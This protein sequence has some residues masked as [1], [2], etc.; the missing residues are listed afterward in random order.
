MSF[1]QAKTARDRLA[2]RCPMHVDQA[3][4]IVEQLLAYVTALHSAGR[5]HG[6]I[7]AQLIEVADDGALKLEEP[8]PVV[9]FGD[10]ID[11]ME[12]YPTEL[13]PIL[14][15]DIPVEI[16]AVV[17]LFAKL[18]VDCDPV[19]IDVHQFGVL[20]CRLLSGQ[21]VAEYLQSARARSLVPAAFRNL[22]DHA[23]GC[24]AVA[25]YHNLSEFAAG[26]TD[27]VRS[28]EAPV[29]SNNISND[30]QGIESSFSETPPVHRNV[31]TIPETPI[32]GLQEPSRSMTLADGS[33]M[34]TY[35]IIKHIGGG[36]MGDVYQAYEEL[37]DRYVAIKVLP[38]ELARHEGFVRR[39]HAEA[40]AVAKLSA[41]Q[42]RG[43][44]TPSAKT[45]AIISSQCNM[46]TAN[47]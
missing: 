43:K 24:S 35:R 45:M 23:L 36:G 10:G 1:D 22:I 17:N 25:R 27:A 40:A 46:S 31:V 32:H 38:P 28:F 21:S 14:P 6:H 4:E 2:D 34:G 5:L 9:S 33:R 26:L 19:R 30:S 29:A 42:H 44:F 47:R 39:F 20:F 3:V 8:P 15:I 37:L 41:S 11:P 12:L 18:K 13:Q 16:K 7:V